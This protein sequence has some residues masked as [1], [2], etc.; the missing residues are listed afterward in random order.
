MTLSTPR[1][2]GPNRSEKTDHSADNPVVLTGGT[3]LTCD[4]EDTEAEAI[5]IAG[6]RILAVGDL[7]TVRSAAGSEARVVDLDG[8][9]VLPGLIDTHPH[10]LHLGVMAYPLVQLDDAVDHDDI[11]ARIAAKAAQTP[12]GQWVMTMPVGE[13]SYFIRRSWRD[14]REGE[15]P[16]REVLDRATTE[17]P[18]LIQAWGP[19][20]PNVMVFNSAG[21]RAVGIDSSTPDRVE[22]VEIEK[23]A[24]GVPTGRL[25]GRVNN[26][27]SGDPFTEQ[28][29]RELPIF[30]PAAVLPGT[31]HAM[32]EY[33][34]LGVTTVYEGHSLDFPEIGAYQALRDADAM[35]LRV[36]CCP[37]AQ[38]NGLPGSAPIDDEALIARLEQAAAM[39]QRTDDMLRVDGISFG[40]GGPIS[41]GM[42]LMRDPYQDPDGNPTVGASFLS[43]Q[44]AETIIRFAYEH[45][46]R[47]NIVTAGTAEHDVNLDVLEKLAGGGTL[48]TEGRAWLLQHLY[49]FEPEHARRAAALGLDV[50]TSMSFSWGKGE[51]ARERIG[52]HMLEHLIPLRRL[53]D[54]GLRVGCGTDWGP[55]NVFEHIAL[56]VEPTYAGTGAKAP[57]PGISRKEAL[58]MWTRDAAHVL[59]WEG[60]GSLE[61]GNWADLVV[62]DR[63]PLTC[64]VEDLPATEV[65]AT[66]LAGE[67]VHGSLE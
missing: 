57:T 64:P 39:V 44:R 67:L 1:E 40:R 66:L 16:T 41:S 60:I 42:I 34:A 46:L 8:A 65:W 37:E 43:A 62:V 51:L 13:P 10:V 32:R 3:V 11:V 2:T 17:H 33:N 53:L 18:V 35:T 49:F 50:T 31:Q 20:T 45:G 30:D 22:S 21:L 25:Y 61:P 14:L 52:E 28:L 59:R 55:K 48:D 56:A 5:A 9:T 38:P 27:Y 47:L 54:A 24:N 23:D 12:A 58:A 36:L 6:G 19:T 7:E 15:L 4:R 26:I 63:N 29:M